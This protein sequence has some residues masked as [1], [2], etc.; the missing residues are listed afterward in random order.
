M[1]KEVD[2]VSREDVLFGLIL[3]EEN[4]YSF[5]WAENIL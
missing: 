1:E 2:Y 3:N 5:C 4:G